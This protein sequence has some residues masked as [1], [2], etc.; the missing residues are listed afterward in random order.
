LNLSGIKL[1][2]RYLTHPRSRRGS[3]QVIW[4]DILTAF[5]EHP[6]IKYTY[7]TIRYVGL[8]DDKGESKPD[9]LNQAD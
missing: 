2:V 3:E 1:T 5:A 8:N 4:E 6:D 9:F 7:Q